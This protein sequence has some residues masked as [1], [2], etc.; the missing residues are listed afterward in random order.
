M[1]HAFLPT[2]RLPGL[3]G[4]RPR[5][6]ATPG[7]AR[8]GQVLKFQ[9][10][11]GSGGTRADQG[12]CPTRRHEGERGFALLLVFLMAAVIGIMLWSQL[13][14]VAIQSQRA[15]EQLLIERG[16]QFKRAIQLFMRANKGAPRYPADMDDLDRGY[17]NLRSCAI[18]TRIR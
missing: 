16:E 2:G 11:S 10:K 5:P 4:G 18:A 13:P 15:K 8:P 12:V 7:R 9:T 3:W 14:R 6:R 17:N 1:P